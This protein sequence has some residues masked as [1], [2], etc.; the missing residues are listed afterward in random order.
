M[1]VPTGVIN[2]FLPGRDLRQTRALE[3]EGQG[4][5]AFEQTVE[6]P[7]CQ[8]PAGGS[9]RRSGASSRP[10]ASSSTPENALFLGFWNRQQDAPIALASVTLV[11]A[12]RLCS[13]RSER[14]HDAD[15]GAGEAGAKRRPAR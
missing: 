4:L 11:R 8:V 2:G 9:I 7:R 6:E 5:S 3:N 10:G 12:D 1:Y 14:F 13:F 15:L